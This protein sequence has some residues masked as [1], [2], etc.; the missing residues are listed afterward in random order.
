[1]AAPARSFT[2]VSDIPPL[3]LSTFEPDDHDEARADYAISLW[4][5]QDN[6]LRQRDRQVEE[7]IRMLLGQHWAVW[8]ELKGRFVDLSEHLGTDEKKW[9]HMPV[10][11]RLFIWYVL[12]HAR[13]TENPPIIGFQ[14]GPDRID[15][16]LAEVMDVVFKYIYREAGMIEVLDRLFSWMIPSGRAF[17]KSR[18]DRMKGEP[19]LSRGSAKLQLLNPE[20]SPIL[21]PDGQPIQ[22]E[23]N[24]VPFDPDGKPLARLTPEGQVEGLDAEPHVFYEGAIAVDL[25]T[26]L[27]A[28]GEWGANRPWHDKSWHMQLS[29][30]TPL[31]AYEAL[32]VE[33]EPDIRGE[34]AESIGTFW[35]MLHGSGIF[36]AAE[37]RTHTGTYEGTEFVSLYELWQRPSRFKGM[38]R[39]KESPGGRLLQVTGGKVVLRDGPRF[40]PFRY[41]S[42]IR[43]FD[44]HKLPGRPQGSSPQEQINGPIRTRNRMAAQAINHA[45]LVA[46]PLRVL[47]RSQGLELGKV[48]NIP[49]AEVEVDRSKSKAPP[50]EYAAPGQLG[51]DVYRV[52]DMLTR[53]IDEIGSIA[54]TSGE[55]P[56][57]DASGELVKE[58]RFNSDR[59]IASTMRAAVFEIGRIAEDW[60]VMVPVIWDQEKILSIVGEDQI[61]RTVTVWPE[62]FQQGSVNVEPSVES[63]LPEGRGERQQRVY[64][65]WRDGFF[66]NPQSPEAM[67]AFFEN[68]RYPHVSRFTR[69]GG[70]DRTTAQQRVGMLLQDA[71][72]SSL[73]VYEWY[74]F[75]T[76][77][78]V[79]E[80]FMKSPEYVKQPPPIQ[81]EMVVYRELLFEGAQY[82]A[83]K[84]IARQ[85]ALELATQAS[86]QA[87]VTT[88]GQAGM[89]FQLGAGT[90]DGHTPPAAGSAASGLPRTK[91]AVA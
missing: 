14:A 63:M 67:N 71:P 49:G 1:M 60:Q 10:L 76:H 41:T 32:G 25:L 28:R 4:K 42:P 72:A 81:Q 77:I 6:L 43:C 50:V 55:I 56:T 2:R 61:A 40:A 90:P 16:Q 8:S 38:Q 66:G 51:T 84:L 53:E 48:P 73:P 37:A 9:R 34:Q 12:H 26:C 57:E 30:L 83:A 15:A 46:N 24:D 52:S 36:G 85:T 20:G 27:E 7:N 87:A 21:G 39:T 79:L 88:M 59:P 44:F 29:L 82:A 31:Q 3:R 91:G 19:I 74:D 78:N 17:L 69:P 80:Q 33:L 62:M 58:L 47:D 45:T 5:S 89:P 11:N 54:G 65:L 13:M 35:R 86:M 70:V 18:I 68:V 23:V 75:A 22:R 64:M